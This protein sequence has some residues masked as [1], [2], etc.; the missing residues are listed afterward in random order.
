MNAIAA[1]SHV[2]PYP[3]YRSLLAGPALAFDPELKL[4]IASR[5][6]V[7]REVMANPACVVR[8]VGEA[9]PKAIAGSSAG[10]IFSRLVRMNEGAAH[11]DTKMAIK[12]SLAALDLNEVARRTSHCA[13][14]LADRPI[15]RWVVDLPSYVVADLLGLEEAELP[16]VALL[17]ADFVRCLSPLSTPNQLAGASTAAQALMVRFSELR[18]PAGVDLANLIGLL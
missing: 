4:W 3:Y 5:A 11:A 12:Q 8:P 6:A 7:V 18:M 17:M 16:R 13:A 14:M 9:V 1:A 2:A 10:E 15:N